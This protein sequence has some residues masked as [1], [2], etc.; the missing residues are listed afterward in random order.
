[1]TVTFAFYSSAAGGTP[2]WQEP[3]IVTLEDGYFSARLGT[4]TPF[5]PATLFDGAS[6]YLGITIGTDTEMVPR[7]AVASVPY[8]LVAGDVTG[9]IHPTSVTVNG[10]EIIDGTGAWVGSA[11]PAGATGPVG[12][13]GPPGP[14][15]ADGPPGPPGPSSTTNFGHKDWVNGVTQGAGY[16]VTVNDSLLSIVTSGAPLMI[17]VNTYLNGG[18]HATC[19]PV[20][21]GV[22]AG[23]YG[24]LPNPGDPKWQEGLVDT[25]LGGWHPW[26]KTRIYPG[27]PAG[28]HQLQV[29]CATDG[30]TLGVCNSGSVACSVHFVELK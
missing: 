26:Q 6:R 16:W 29:Q 19:R 25:G 28:P 7:Q 23:Q 17:T 30:G 11:P 15:G 22:W 2:L 3:Q 8:A 18:S 9:D 27:V 21:D 13:M 5:D 20:I 1:V 14:A 12:P 10:V 4:V 24:M